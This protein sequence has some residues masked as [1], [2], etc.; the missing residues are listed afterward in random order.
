MPVHSSIVVGDFPSTAVTLIWI[1]VTQIGMLCNTRD[2]VLPTFMS[3]VGIMYEEKPILQ[4]F[5]DFP[6]TLGVVIL[7]VMI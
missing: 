4:A 2:T 3:V 6:V 1:K 5:Q 7:T